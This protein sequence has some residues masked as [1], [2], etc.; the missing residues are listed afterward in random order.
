MRVRRESLI[1]T[2]GPYRLPCE[3]WAPEGEAGA[4]A[5][6]ALVLC[7]GSTQKGMRHEFIRHLASSLSRRWPTLAFDL[8]GLGRA[9]RLVVRGLDD[10]LYYEHALAAARLARELTGLPAVLIGH[11]MGG[12]VALQAASRADRGL[13]AGV[14]TLAG[15]YDLPADPSEMMELLTDF[16][17]YVRVRF[18]IP[19]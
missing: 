17:S 1:L 9:P 12:R 10:Y 8:P 6:V 15:L 18:E 7:H 11:S 5:D 16:A 3:L 13:V 2:S 4:E 19:L 14:I